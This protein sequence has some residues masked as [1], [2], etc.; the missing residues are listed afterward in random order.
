MLFGLDGVEVG[1]IIVFL[2]LLGAIISGFPVAFA[3][4]GA[5]II[6]FGVIAALDLRVS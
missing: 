3:L 2:S 6:S 5:G 1:L 4:G